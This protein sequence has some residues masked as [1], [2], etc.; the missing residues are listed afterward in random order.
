MGS[1]KHLN[2]YFFKYKFHL[3]GGFIF[4][5]LSNL[6][7]IYPAQVTRYTIDYL[8][9]AVWLNQQSSGSHIQ[10][11]LLE[12]FF[13]IFFIF[14]L[15]IIAT[16]LIKGVFMFFMRQTI[17]VMS[18][19]IEYDLKN[20][21]YKHYQI[22]PLS[23]YKQNRTGDL[24]ARISEDVSQVRMYI[25]P[26]VM[27]ALNLIV[28]FILVIG[29]MWKVN[30][31]LTLLVLIPLPFLSI[32]IYFISNIINH[33]SSKVQ[34][35]L[36]NLSSASQSS[37]A[38][39]RVIKSFNREDQNIREF[40]TE[41]LTFK[42]LSLKLMRIDSLFAPVI[43]LLIGASTIITIYIG[44]KQYINGSITLGNIAEFVIYVN[45]L[46]W[47]VTS[48]GWVS[49]IIQK[50]AVSQKRI[51][52]F[53]NTKNELKNGK[54]IL[55]K[56]DSISIRF[57]HVSFTYPESGIKALNNISFYVPTGT[58]IGITGKTG[59]GKTTIALLLARLYDVDEGE[60]L[61][62]EIN[63]N[64]YEINH[65]R[66]S[67][68]YVPQDV[69]LFSESIYNNIVFGIDEQEKIL[70]QRVDEV[71]ND[72]DILENI[73]GFSEGFQTVIGERGVTLS[74]GQKQRLSIARALIKNPRMLILDDCLSAVD[75]STENRI[76][77]NL[78]N[79]LNNN[80]V[81]YISHRI[82]T[83]QHANQL[84]VISNHQLV[85][86]GTHE[87]LIA[88]KGEYFEQYQS[89]LMQPEAIA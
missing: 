66:E 88:L 13:A 31:Y 69:F 86:Q 79:R 11:Y 40:L 80:T 65:L 71:A 35:Q 77:Q 81:I 6:F 28:L 47:P 55:N 9:E 26:A 76:L 32:G 60:I 82:S 29:V 42:S 89:Q 33:K 14:F 46:T 83:V 1:L 12:Q 21:I 52:E 87:Q 38:G 48:I 45:M 41:S 3:L 16:T 44:G 17:I 67:I 19:H 10:S 51:N 5:I 30:S 4:I 27:Y 72:A 24:M 84:I 61:I 85:E 49:S 37:F 22:L 57:N 7:A 58:S 36:S 68:G 34:A 39:I 50:A 73:K 75:T 23:F 20:E 43:T 56:G 59:S 74:G 8:H 62:N 64:Q 63:I 18:R 54:L 15:I 2:K 78:K 53:L 70:K 25:G